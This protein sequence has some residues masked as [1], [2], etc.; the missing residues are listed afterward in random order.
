MSY[1]VMIARRHLRSMRKRRRV[2]FTAMIGALGVAIGVAALAIVLSVMNGFSGMI[3]NRL[4]GVNAHITVR[5]AYEERIEDHGALVRTLEAHPEVVGAS[6]FIQAEGFLLRRAPTGGMLNSGVLVRGVDAERLLQT[7]DLDNHLWAGEVD[8][9]PREVEGKRADGVLIGYVLADKLGAMLGSEIHLGIFPKGKMA[10]Q[11]PPLRRYVVTGIFNTGYYEFDSGLVFI[12]LPSAQRDLEWGDVVTGV[13]LRLRDPFES[14]RVSRELREVLRETFPDV[15]ASSWMS[16]H[17]NLYVWIRLEK[18]FF[19]IA[20]SLIVTVAGFNIISILTMSVSERRREI[21]ILKTMGATP[22]SIG[23]IFTMEGLAVGAAGV[24]LGDAVGFLVCWL[25]Q[26]YELIKLPGEVYIISALP[27]E[28][29]V[30]D[31]VLISCSAL[32]LC[33]LFTR[34]PARDAASLDPVE[35]IR[36]E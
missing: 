21:G 17:G 20:L 11:L 7:S 13:R 12:S 8:L 23:R 34:F 25:Q 6:A 10:F 29:Q 2:S 18:W 28:M 32:L 31:F 36:Y 27:V 16:E 14:G 15:F 5:R 26:R 4:L 1:E 30:G 9:L 3:W 24:F 33:Y 19:F 22:Q 35:A